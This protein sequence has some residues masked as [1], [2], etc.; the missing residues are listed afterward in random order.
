MFFF[1]CSLSLFFFALPSDQILPHFVAQLPIKEDEECAQ[2]SHEHL[3][4]FVE[5][6]QNGLRTCLPA[7]RNVFQSVL[8]SAT[9]GGGGGGDDAVVLATPAVMQRIR[10]VLATLPQ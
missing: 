5:Q 8:V 2:I 3:C 4:A 9:A 1:S 7:V 6:G 10:T